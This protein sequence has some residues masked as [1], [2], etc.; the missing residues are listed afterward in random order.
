ME[1]SLS[2]AL[3]S[4]K[5]VPKPMCKFI[6]AAQALAT[7]RAITADA[8]KTTKPMPHPIKKPTAA[9]WDS[10]DPFLVKACV[11]TGEQHLQGPGQAPKACV[12]PAS[13]VTTIPPASTK[14]SAFDPPCLPS[15]A[16]LPS[17]SKPLSKRNANTIDTT[18]SK[19][20]HTMDGEQGEG[21]A[22]IFWTLTLLALC[23]MAL[24]FN[25]H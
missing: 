8:T 11:G 18:G 4:I 5:V 25:F 10:V 6:A 16:P 9:I 12:A 14:P 13:H 1:A 15:T 2:K 17:T 23:L 20:P 22:P 19:K 21:S 7:A 3:P 24:T